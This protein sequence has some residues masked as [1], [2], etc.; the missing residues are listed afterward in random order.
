MYACSNLVWQT[1]I[2]SLQLTLLH[3]VIASLKALEQLNI[4]LNADIGL[5]WENTIVVMYT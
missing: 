5:I 1:E 4:Q 2:K 3:H